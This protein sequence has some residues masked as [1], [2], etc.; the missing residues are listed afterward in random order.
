MHVFIVFPSK[1]EDRAVLTFF[2]FVL[3]IIFKNNYSR[4]YAMSQIRLG[5]QMEIS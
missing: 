4:I 1:L 2:L 3:V 5:I